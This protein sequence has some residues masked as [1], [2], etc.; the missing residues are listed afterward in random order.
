SS[1][2]SS[3]EDPRN[4]KGLPPIGSSSSEGESISSSEEESTPSEEGSSS[5]PLS[6]SSWNRSWRSSPSVL[7]SSSSETTPKSNSFVS[8]CRG[9]SASYAAVGSHSG[10]GSRLSGM[11]SMEEA[12]RGEEEGEEEEEESLKELESEEEEIAIAGGLGF[13]ALL[14]F[15]WKKEFAVKKRRF[16]VRLN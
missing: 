12:G 9:A 2:L 1:S 5:S 6:D 3:S 14:G 4:R 16:G 15:R 13:S 7:G 10:V 8:Q 11:E